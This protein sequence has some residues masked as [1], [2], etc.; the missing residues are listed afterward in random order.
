[1]HS[2]WLCCSERRKLKGDRGDPQKL[3]VSVRMCGAK[4]FACWLL[5]FFSLGVLLGQLIAEETHVHLL[6]DIVQENSW[7]WLL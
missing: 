3:R 4:G 5:V 7:E 2:S 6:H 1:V